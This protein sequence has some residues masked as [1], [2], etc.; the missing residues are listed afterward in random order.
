MQECC[1]SYA[2]KLYKYVRYL[3]CINSMFALEKE[4]QIDKIV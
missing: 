4:Y 3:Y 2:V 1:V